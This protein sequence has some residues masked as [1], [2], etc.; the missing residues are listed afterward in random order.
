MIGAAATID[1]RGPKFCRTIFA[2]CAIACRTK[3]EPASGPGSS[4]VPHLVCND[5]NH[6]FGSVRQGDRLTYAFTLRNTGFAALQILN[7][8][9]SH[10][11]A[12]NY[13]PRRIAPGESANLEIVC[14]T[15]ERVNRLEEKLRV[16]SNDPMDPALVLSVTARIE[17]R[18]AFGSRTVE[19]RAAFG[20]EDSHEVRLI[21]NLAFAAT[22]AVDA[23]EPAGIKVK[24]IS[25]DKERP[26]GLRLTCAGLH[27]GHI[28]GQVRVTTGLEK[29]S[30]LT[31]LYT[32]QVI[33][34]VSVE[35]TNPYVDLRAPGPAGVVVHVSSSRADFR[36]DQV[37]A[38]DGPFEASSARDS[39]GNGYW[40]R[41]SIRGSPPSDDRGA[42]GTLR[43]LSNDPAEPQKDVPLIA[44][45]PLNQGDR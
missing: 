9:Q 24:V 43:L 44:L 1:S 38:V 23:V 20:K 5:T 25:A 39:G 27:V 33:G 10:S 12:A 11:C 16:H 41:I 7:V 17:P 32:C 8:A 4:D 15:E 14:D 19:I 13:P 31:L 40:V 3:G 30:H 36:L 18:L 35:P 29:P 2:L 45:G 28:L 22:L 34:N 26:Q 21:G 37:Q 6:D 42:I